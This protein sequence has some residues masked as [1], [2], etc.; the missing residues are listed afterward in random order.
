[1]TVTHSILL[2]AAAL[3]AGGL[4][5][6]AGG[7]SFFSF[8]AL[9][10]TGV[11]PIPANATSALAVWPGSLASAWAYRKR[12]PR[13]PR[14]LLPLIAASLLGGLAGATLLLHTPQSSFIRLLP[15]LFLGATALFAYGKRLA[16]F[17]G[18]HGPHPADP[19]WLWITLVSLVQMVI[20]VYGGYFGGGMGI[21]MLALLSLL[22]LGDVHGMNGVKALLAASANG[23]AI[24]TFILAGIILWPQA[25]LMTVG[26]M[27]GGF[28]GA[29]F[30]QK[31]NP[32]KVRWLVVVV[33]T[34]MSVYFFWRYR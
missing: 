6:V 27:L 34:A 1:M 7:G 15:F 17:F 19:S 24:T 32:G 4:N 16:G 13:S 26:A 25:L 30:A 21:M 3:M 2:F 10:F 18:A 28:T 31:F 29:H 23:V 33:G 22:P 12:L 11:F 5:S 8:P 20:A 9:L 14:L